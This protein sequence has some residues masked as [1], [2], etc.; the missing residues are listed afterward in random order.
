MSFY[1]L[2]I[3]FLH[4]RNVQ[5]IAFPHRNLSFKFRIVIGVWIIYC[6]IIS[7]AYSG[8]L[9]AFLTTPS[10]S[11]PMNSLKDV[12]ESGLPWGMVL[13]GEDEERLMQQSQDPIIQTIW[14][15]K[16]EEPYRPVPPV[17]LLLQDRKS[18]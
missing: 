18:E 9:K 12:V 7:S 6:L 17:R 5:G 1:P 15:E 11:D 14:R 10:F 3:R 2:L 13:Y 16:I 4:I 8:N